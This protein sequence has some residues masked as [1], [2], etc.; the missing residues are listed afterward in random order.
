MYSRRRRYSAAPS[1]QTRRLPFALCERL[2]AGSG[3]SKGGLQASRHGLQ[4]AK[5][6]AEILGVK[7]AYSTNGHGIVEFDFTTGKERRVDSFPKPAELWQRFRASEKIEDDET[8][9][10]MLT[11]A[12]A[13]IGKG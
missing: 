9:S 8:A 5:D 13:A 4:Q 7:F 10:R 1:L 11:P 2:Y 6:Y 3:R 12:N